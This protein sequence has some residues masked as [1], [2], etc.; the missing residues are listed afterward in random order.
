[1]PL[2]GFEP[3]I[4]AGERPQTHA[5]DGAATGTGYDGQYIVS[6]IKVKRSA[7]PGHLMCINDNRT[8]KKVYD[9]KPDGVRRVGRQKL[10]WEDSVNQDMRILQVKNWKKVAPTETNGQSL[11]ARVHQGLSSQ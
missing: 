9:S 5:L 4:S 1:M 8:L 3:S 10:L 11:K 6:Y 7:W 2:V